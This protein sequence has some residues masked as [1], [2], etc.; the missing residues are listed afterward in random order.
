MSCTELGYKKSV[1]VG[2][3]VGYHSLMTINTIL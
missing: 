2:V 3:C 1:V